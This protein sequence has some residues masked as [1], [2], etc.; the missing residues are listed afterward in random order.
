M[1]VWEMIVNLGF[2]LH[3]VH[4]YAGPRQAGGRTNEWGLPL[5]SINCQLC[6]TRYCC[7]CCCSAA[8][9]LL[10]TAKG[11]AEKELKRQKKKKGG[12]GSNTQDQSWAS[13]ATDERSVG[14]YWRFLAGGAGVAHD[15]KSGPWGADFPGE[16]VGKTIQ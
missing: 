13:W 16:A 4:A 2:L 3:V 12:G 6:L 9:Q 8:A 7:C 11:Y 5:T 14:W 15:V 10:A 1:F